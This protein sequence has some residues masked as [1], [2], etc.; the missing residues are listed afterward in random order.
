MSDNIKQNSIYPIEIKGLEYPFNS[1]DFGNDFQAMIGDIDNNFSQLQH[2]G[3][4]YCGSTGS[5]PN[6]R[7]YDIFTTEGTDMILTDIGVKLINT[8]LT[9]ESDVDDILFNEG[10]VV[11][12]WDKAKNILDSAFPPVS[13]NGV[14]ISSFFENANGKPECIWPMWEYANS[15]GEIGIIPSAPFIFY[16]KRVGDLASNGGLFLTKDNNTD[17]EDMSCVITGTLTDSEIDLRKDLL[18]PTLYYDMNVRGDDTGEGSW[19]WCLNGQ[20]TGIQAEGIRGKDAEG[21]IHLIKEKL[22][23][24]GTKYYTYMY[25][26]LWLDE[27]SYKEVV[28]IDLGDIGWMLEVSTVTDSS[29]FNALNSN[30]FVVQYDDKGD[31]VKTGS[32]DEDSANISFNSDFFNFIWKPIT[33]SWTCLQQDYN[34]YNNT[35]NSIKVNVLKYDGEYEPSGDQRFIEIYLNDINFKDIDRV[36]EI[37]ENGDYITLV[38]D[39]DKHIEVN[40]LNSDLQFHINSS[41]IVSKGGNYFRFRNSE[42]DNSKDGKALP[43]TT[44]DYDI[45]DYS[46]TDYYKI[47][48]TY[49]EWRGDKYV[50]LTTN[51]Y[52]VRGDGNLYIFEDGGSRIG[53]VNSDF[54][55]ESDLPDFSLIDSNDKI[56]LLLYVDSDDNIYEYTTSTI[57]P[58]L[59]SLSW[60]N[61]DEK[62]FSIRNIVDDLDTPTTMDLVIEKD[63][64]SKVGSTNLIF[65]N[66]SNV[67]VDTGGG[68]EVHLNKLSNLYDQIF[69][70]YDDI[71]KFFKGEIGDLKSVYFGDNGYINTA[72]KYIPYDCDV[73][74]NKP[75][76]ID[77]NPTIIYSVKG[78]STNYMYSN[79]QAV[80]RNL[81][82]DIYTPGKLLD[83]IKEVD[84]LTIT[85]N[86]WFN[87]TNIDKLSN[88]SIE[89]SK[90]VVYGDS[91]LISRCN[92]EDCVVYID[93]SI[94]SEFYGPKGFVKIFDNC[95][96]SKG[97][98]TYDRYNANNT[99]SKILVRSGVNTYPLFTYS[100][101]V[102]STSEVAGNDIILLD[103]DY[104]IVSSTPTYYIIKNSFNFGEQY[105]KYIK[106]IE[107]PR[108]YMNYKWIALGEESNQ[109]NNYDNWFKDWYNLERVDNIYLRSPY[110]VVNMFKNC[111][112][113]EEVT[114][115]LDNNYNNS[116]NITTGVFNS[117]ISLRKVTLPKNFIDSN[118]SLNRTLLLEKDFESVDNGDNTFSS[119]NYKIPI[120]CCIIDEV[121]TYTKDSVFYIKTN[122]GKVDIFN[123]QEHIEDSSFEG[124]EDLTD[125]DIDNFLDKE[126][127]FFKI[128]DQ[129]IDIVNIIKESGEG[130]YENVTRLVIPYDFIVK[131]ETIS[132]IDV[133]IKDKTYQIINFTKLCCGFGDLEELVLHPYDISKLPICYCREAFWGCKNIDRTRIPNYLDNPYRVFSDKTI[134]QLL[135]DYEFGWYL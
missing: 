80:I 87:I 61:G 24:Y 13:T 133:D 73:D 88:A 39:L 78:D 86:T 107:F 10:M 102:N 1:S 129:D 55:E 57:T 25:N 64:I 8:I 65:R 132:K 4:I 21:R 100:I 35:N 117:C 51:E 72:N 50:P 37:E 89:L 94:A 96:D 56:N 20:H 108:S 2:Q 126:F 42:F 23:S 111:I 45:N 118:I 112:R 69:S 77:C 103:D 75:I 26:R 125:L 18:F 58:S 32:T 124:G 90:D 41:F 130:A 54:K 134:E 128:K 3:G 22:D 106:S 34:N 52:E 71:R 74:I 36:Y 63:S 60:N 66:F 135:D 110:T 97:V 91:S 48:D 5:T 49:Y 15:I 95:F 116:N 46:I 83:S 85:S 7:Y 11:K 16:D 28:P 6:I 92:I 99:N 119:N 105:K 82:L 114:I 44:I 33:D 67:I 84:K 9:K 68:S 62:A 115:K 40:G 113:L 76:L 120:E 27:K 93:E 19:C 122:K 47:G 109:Y 81:T 79:S 59:E 31:W 29:D 12:S 104:S 127:I 123:F 70:T 98:V 53:I 121:N 101:E 14:L 43:L 131:D 30:I 38:E 17:F